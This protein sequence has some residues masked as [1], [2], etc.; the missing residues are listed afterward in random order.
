LKEEQTSPSIMQQKVPPICRP[1]FFACCHTTLLHKHGTPTLP[2]SPFMAWHVRHALPRLRS[3]FWSGLCPPLCKAIPPCSRQQQQRREPQ[4]WSHASWSPH[5]WAQQPEASKS[6]PP[7][8][9]WNPTICG[10]RVAGQIGRRRIQR[11]GCH[12]KPGRGRV[13]GGELGGT[14]REGRRGRGESTAESTQREHGQRERDWAMIMAA[15]VLMAAVLCHAAALLCC[16]VQLCPTG[17]SSIL[18]WG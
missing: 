1:S 6:P 9:V 11:Y 17:P 14:Q 2:L 15:Y 13:R 18:L 3:G 10:A 16:P 7:A 4:D 8:V 12:P 5:A